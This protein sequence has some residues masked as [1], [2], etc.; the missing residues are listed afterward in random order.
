[1]TNIKLYN[2]IS[3]VGLAV[4]DKSKYSVGEDVADPEGILVRSAALH[5]E[6]F[7]KELLC[8][9]RAGAGVNNIPIDRCSE[10]G[11]VVFNTPGANANGVK[12]LAI[13]AL[14]LASRD[15]V[16]GIEWAKTLKGD[17][18]V[19]KAVE[20]GK[21]RFA[22]PEIKG[23]TLGVIGL[24]AI[25]GM[26][27]NAAYGV[28]MK[29]VGCDPYIT[30]KNA[31]SLSRA[32]KKADDYDELYA[33]SDYITYHIPAIP[34]TK[35]IINK[36]NISKMKDGVRIINLSRGDLCNIPDLL[37]ALASGKVAAYVT[38]FPCEELLGVPGVV[39][40]PHLGAST[41]ESEDNCAVMAAE[42]MIEYLENGNI[43]NSVNYPEISLP[44]TAKNRVIALHENVPN[45][46]SQIS[47]ALST[48]GVNI[49][50]L[51]SQSKGANAI[52]L[53]DTNDA[54]SAKAIDDIRAIKG[55]VR[56]IVR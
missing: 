3:P 17:P 39:A 36:E 1:M 51:L 56:V 32:V 5:E 48:D 27:A 29:V 45:M 50:S 4:F 21:S 49:E 46:L 40:I 37:E 13:A 43:R 42:E 16:G 28:G 22:G 35:G 20:K 11:I 41:P 24:G 54:V 2:K 30:V 34:A 19:A 8:I 25:G 7:G 52:S 31:W 18:D 47:G 44:R 6:P 53:F 55:V 10:N 23:K 38:D 15:V 26:V 9:A 12:E 14:L 33:E